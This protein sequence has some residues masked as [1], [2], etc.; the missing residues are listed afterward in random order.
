MTQKINT[1]YACLIITLWGAFA[2]V[3]ILHAVESSIPLILIGTFAD[4]SAAP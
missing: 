2:T 1:Y 4:V 3:L